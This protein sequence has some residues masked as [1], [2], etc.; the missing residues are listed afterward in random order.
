MPQSCENVIFI[1]GHL[2]F[3]TFQICRSS[4][5]V[6]PRTRVCQKRFPNF[7][8]STYC[9]LNNDKNI[10]METNAKDTTLNTSTSFEDDG[11]VSVEYRVVNNGSNINNCNVAMTSTPS[12]AIGTLGNDNTIRMPKRTRNQ[13]WIAVV[14]GMAVLFCFA[15]G[16]YFFLKPS[17]PKPTLSSALV[18]KSTTTSITRSELLQHSDP[19]NDCWIVLYD[20]VYDVTQY[21]PTHPGG[22]QYVTDYCGGNA[23][24]EYTKQHPM[25]YIDIYLSSNTV[26][27]IL[28]T[29][30]TTASSNDTKG[31]VMSHRTNGTATVNAPS[32]VVR[33]SPTASPVIK[34]VDTG[35]T[36][37]TATNVPTVE[38][39]LGCISLNEVLLHSS[40]SDCYYILYGYVYDMTNYI[41]EHPGGRRNI[42]QECGTDAT[43]VYETQKFHN[44]QLLLD[45]NAVEL[46][47]LG[48]TCSD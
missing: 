32:E 5:Y 39:T 15:L 24:R 3:T 42:F 21:A 28:S 43:Q 4:A 35:S 27:G 34:N 11:S 16:M 14:L 20:T 45:I 1:A 2:I 22:S 44:E 18:E 17:H 47:G 40:I 38:P 25:K 46:Y 29:I 13:R 26:K 41:D 36:S 7:Y 48:F 6:F 33:N 30:S 31:N 37:A 23:T 10:S 8:K 9:Y 19:I 12:R